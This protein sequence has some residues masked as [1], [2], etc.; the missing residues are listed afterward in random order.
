MV[1]V[2]SYDL[3]KPLFWASKP[4]VASLETWEWTTRVRDPTLEL[5]RHNERFIFLFVQ[6]KFQASAVFSSLTLVLSG[7][8]SMFRI[9]DQIPFLKQLAV[10]VFL[11]S[12]GN[13]PFQ[14]TFVFQL[15]SL[16][17]R[18]P[19]LTFYFNLRSA[20]SILLFL[21]A[22]SNILLKLCAVLYLTV[23]K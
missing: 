12:L 1:V 21:C 14:T 9:R 6:K 10:E 11:D 20:N 2:S 15:S 23:I 19:M 8:H 13:T 4:L 16:S 17:S 3:L 5:H 7:G 18:I 22:D